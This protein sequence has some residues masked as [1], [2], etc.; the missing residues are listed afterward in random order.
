VQ[1]DRG[2]VDPHGHS[3]IDAPHAGIGAQP[4]AQHWLAFA[5][6]EIA[7]ALPAGMVRMRVRHHRAL[8]R[9]PWAMWNPP[10]S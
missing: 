9:A 5:R 4:G 2:F 1:R 6:I 7:A 3:P 10:A 8:D